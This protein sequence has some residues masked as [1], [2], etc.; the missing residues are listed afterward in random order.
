[1]TT[2]IS[3]KFL[4]LDLKKSYPRLTFFI[5][6]VK[7]NNKKPQIKTKPKSST[8]TPLPQN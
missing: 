6:I 1:M 8:E 4:K 2:D 3:P 5:K 7:W